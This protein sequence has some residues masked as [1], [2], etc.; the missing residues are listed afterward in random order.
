MI[1]SNQITV[2]S[3][4]WVLKVQYWAKLSI[5]STG[6]EQDTCFQKY[7]FRSCLISI[8]RHDVCVYAP[9]T[10]M[11]RL[12]LQT[13]TSV[14]Y[15]LYLVNRSNMFFVCCSRSAEKYK[16]KGSRAPYHAFLVCLFLWD[17]EV[18]MNWRR[19]KLYI[20]ISAE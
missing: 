16:T 13:Y 15:V 5:E 9:L 2:L 14:V 20:M 7:D 8:R 10:F 3:L 18:D 6:I 17:L 1:L 4:I 19:W 11:R 12:T